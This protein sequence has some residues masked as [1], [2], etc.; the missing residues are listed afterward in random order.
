M[1]VFTRKPVAIGVVPVEELGPGKKTFK[2]RNDRLQC[3]NGPRRQSRK[4]PKRPSTHPTSGG[5]GVRKTDRYIGGREG[6]NG[7]PWGR[8]A[9]E[10]NAN[11]SVK[12]KGV[13]RVFVPPLNEPSEG[14]K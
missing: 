5:G 12:R 13:V 1:H 11:N 4:E 8:K 7:S 14:K 3:T 10:T 6:K 9:F 2:G